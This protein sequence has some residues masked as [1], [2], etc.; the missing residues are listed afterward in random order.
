[1]RDWTIGHLGSEESLPPEK[2]LMDPK[3]PA[4]CNGNG[5][6]RLGRSFHP[7]RCLPA[8]QGLPAKRRESVEKLDLLACKEELS[9]DKSYYKEFTQR[10]MFFEDYI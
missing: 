7:A 8:N 9:R 6:R 5:H 4:D 1:L 3:M 2:S 10:E